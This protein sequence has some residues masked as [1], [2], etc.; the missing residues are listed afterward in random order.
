[1]NYI[2]NKLQE[3]VPKKFNSLFNLNMKI[4]RQCKKQHKLEGKQT[5]FMMNAFNYEQSIE[6]QIEQMFDIEKVKYK[7]DTAKCESKQ[8]F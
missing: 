7:C 3:E 6:K 1:M 4:F 8:G 5:Q 2:F